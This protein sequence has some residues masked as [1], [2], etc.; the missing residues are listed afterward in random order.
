MGGVGG[1][2][3]SAPLRSV[4][5]G[6]W[7]LRGGLVARLQLNETVSY[8]ARVTSVSA[9]AELDGELL[10]SDR[11]VHFVPEDCAD[12]APRKDRLYVPEVSL[13]VRPIYQLT[14][15]HLPESVSSSESFL[16][17]RLSSL[18]SSVLTRNVFQ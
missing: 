10:L 18:R 15:V 3:V 1:V 16:Q 4:V 9:A 8:T 7:G 17:N 11:T 2:G 6:W 12:R 14:I 5:G 13:S